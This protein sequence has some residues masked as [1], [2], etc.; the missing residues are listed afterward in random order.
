M[1][2]SGKKK[3][4]KSCFVFKETF[5]FFFSRLVLNLHPTSKCGLISANYSK[6]TAASLLFS[7]HVLVLL[8]ENRIA[9][10]R[11]AFM[12]LLKADQTSGLFVDS[13]RPR[14]H[15]CISF[16]SCIC[17]DS[18]WGGT[19]DVGPAVRRPNPRAPTPA[20][21]L[22]SS[23]CRGQTAALQRN[24]TALTM[25]PSLL[26]YLH[27]GPQTSKQK[28]NKPKSKANAALFAFIS[29]VS[30][31]IGQIGGVCCCCNRPIVLCLGSKPY[32]HYTFHKQTN[33]QRHI[34]GEDEGRWGVLFFF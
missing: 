1:I 23:V 10:A 7:L 32:L 16:R 6:Q 13:R 5:P 25:V 30:A 2:R 26:L 29:P 3:K 17:G 20:F 19:T 31:T 8:L 34:S 24:T 22:Q 21:S 9:S 12:S 27:A 14:K 4:K 28:K 11:P 33:E 18:L 15:A